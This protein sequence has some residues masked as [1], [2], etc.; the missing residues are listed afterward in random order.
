[1]VKGES[2]ITARS[3]PL[4]RFLCS[5]R[6]GADEKAYR[7]HYLDHDNRQI[8]TITYTSLV[9]MLL[10]TLVDLPNLGTQPGLILG[11]YI[12]VL[13]IIF[14]L[15][16]IWVM[17]RLRNSLV[18]DLASVSFVSSIAI[19]FFV[20]HLNSDVSSMRMAA[21]VTILIFSAHMGFPI[22]ALYLFLPMGLII[23]GE[24]YILFSTERTDLLADRAIMLTVFL[25]AECVAVSG[26]ALHHRTRYHAY[27]AIGQVKRLSGML[28]ICANCKKIRDDQGYYRQIEHYITEHTDAEFTHGI[29]PSCVS[30]LYPG[31]VKNAEQ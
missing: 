23:A 30:E 26:S 17:K 24:A 8:S 14:G 29:C 7:E 9:F 10:L 1:M 11:V 27:Q 15:L 3:A 25:F 5:A 13:L 6:P 21:L 28:P 2:E 4:W 16:L 18:T 12:R 19:S 31:F 22:Y 20:Y